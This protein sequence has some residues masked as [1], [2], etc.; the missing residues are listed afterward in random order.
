[1]YKL[2]V[3]DDEQIIREGIINAVISSKTGFE[4]AGQ[5]ANGKQA[6][7]VMPDLMPDLIITDICM[8]WLNGIDFIE[9]AKSL[10]P[11]L[12]VLIVSGYDDFVYAQKALRLGVSDYILKP[13][14]TEKLRSILNRVKEELDTRGN[15]LRDIDDLRKQ[16]QIN[17]PVIRE[18][19]FRE[20]I[21]GEVKPAEMTQRLHKLGLAI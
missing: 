16:V 20:L 21:A 11:D 15:L 1:M 8:P 17:L 9:N 12:K 13:V 6:L 5:A 14:Q 7:E 19:F 4:V 2:M 3:I 18:R 10:N